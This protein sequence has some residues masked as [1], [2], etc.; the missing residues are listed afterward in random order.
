[1][2]ISIWGYVLIHV[3][4]C[5]DEPTDVTSVNATLCTCDVTVEFCDCCC[6]EECTVAEKSLLGKISKVS[7]LPLK[8]H[9]RLPKY[10]LKTAYW[11]E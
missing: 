8:N 3:T 2:K 4:Q 7:Y 11:V 9:F 5:Q 1:M 10:N 6:D